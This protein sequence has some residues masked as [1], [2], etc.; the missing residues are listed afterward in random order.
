MSIRKV[1]AKR[2]SILVLTSLILL[3][4]GISAQAASISGTVANDSGPI[5]GMVGQIQVVVW[6]GDPCGWH[7]VLFSIPIDDSGNYTIPGLEAGYYYLQTSNLNLS[8]YIN[9]WWTG[10]TDPSSYYCDDAVPVDLSGGDQTGIDFKLTTGG[11][12]SGHVYESDG[13]TPIQG[14]WLNAFTGQCYQNEV[15]WADTD[16]DG[17][18]TLRG[19]PPE[20][21]FI[22]A[23]A[24]C[25]GLNYVNE[26]WESGGGT[27][28]CNSAALVASGATGLV[29]TLE[30]GGTV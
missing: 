11:S 19:I 24:T 25:Q 13:T 26:W 17:A 29:F 2:L 28:D 18:F 4:F 10:D 30:Q 23:C 22:S 3:G 16:E 15:A 9:E 8:D 12:I 6:Q 27:V 1:L 21:V 14:M 7:Q 5:A 20:G